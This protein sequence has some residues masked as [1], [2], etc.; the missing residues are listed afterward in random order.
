VAL[1]AVFNAMKKEGYILKDLDLYLLSL[2]NK[3]DN[4]RVINVNAPSAI[5]GCLRARYYS[6]IGAE[7]NPMSIDA[8]LR[9]IFDNGT[10]FHLRMQE[11][12]KKQGM[13]LLDEVPVLNEDYV[14]QGHT[15]GVVKLSAIERAVVE[16]KSIKSGDFVQLK[17]AL[18]D[19]KKQGLTY[20]FCLEERRKVLFSMY[21]S[22]ADFKKDKPKRMKY[23]AKFYQHLK[24]GSK[25][26]K[27]QKI[28][29]QCDLHDQL[30]TILFETRSPLIKTIFMYENKDNQEIKEYCV[31]SKDANAKVLISEVQN[32]CVYLNKCVKT[33]EVPPRCGKSKTDSACRWCDYS[34]ECWL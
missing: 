21:N 6:R 28:Q 25:F 33:G 10:H 22:L 20:L 31:S 26:T 19:H 11:Y 9:R 27:E 14:I 12:L 7:K 23:Y 24:G 4:D 2:N 18:E 16:L 15:D 32:E 29:F 34:T 17:D 5:G 3:K 30:D 13:L 1:K 8:R